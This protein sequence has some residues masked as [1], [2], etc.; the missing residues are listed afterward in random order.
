MAIVQCMALSAA[1][2]VLPGAAAHAA[3]VSRGEDGGGAIMPLGVVVDQAGNSIL[4]PDETVVLA[5]W[6]MNAFHFPHTMAGVTSAFTGPA[7]PTYSNPDTTANY[8][9]LP[10]PGGGSCTAT[11]DCYTVR[12]SAAT[13][14][15]VH[16]HASLRENVNGSFGSSFADW[17]IHVGAS[18]PDVPATSPFYRFVETILHRSVTTG[19]GGLLYCPSTAVARDQMAV[20]VLRTRDPALNPPACA[21]PLFAD[22]PASSPFCRWIEELARRGV[23]SGCGGGHYCPTDPVTREQM[24]V[25]LT[26]TFGLSLN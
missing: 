21:A 17:S 26:G 11:G 23:V 22:V 16:W 8:G 15:A 14:P 9:T 24:A 12:V 3:G 18:F 4:E 7:G 10:G 13:R 19:C 25:F 5:P 6:W 2:A 20:F 1:I